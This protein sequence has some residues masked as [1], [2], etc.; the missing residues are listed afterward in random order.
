MRSVRS[1]RAGDPAK[2]RAHPKSA[3]ALLQAWRVNLRRFPHSNARC[4]TRTIRERDRTK[5]ALRNVASSKHV[6]KSART[7]VRAVSHFFGIGARFRSPARRARLL[8]SRGRRRAAQRRARG[9]ASQRAISPKSALQRSSRGACEAAARDASFSEP[10]RAKTRYV[11]ALSCTL[12]AC[13]LRVKALRS[14]SCSAMMSRPNLGRWLE[15]FHMRA[16]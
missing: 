2:Q 13:M 14:Q 3:R 15:R 8:A 10:S 9:H 6:P 11:S 4:A 7:H 5:T 12:R 1:T 16:A